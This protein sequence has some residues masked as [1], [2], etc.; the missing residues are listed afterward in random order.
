MWHMKQGTDGIS[1]PISGLAQIDGTIHEAG[2]I[3]QPVFPR[4]AAAGMTDIAPSFRSRAAGFSSRLLQAMGAALAEEVLLFDR[5]V[6]G[7]IPTD[8][9]SL[10]FRV[11]YRS[12]DRTLTDVEVDAQHAQVVE[13]ARAR[14]GAKLRA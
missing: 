7:S 2:G 8:H 12:P 10:A 11:I 6:G 9:A 14:F 13:S 1:E 4:S 5:F 3:S